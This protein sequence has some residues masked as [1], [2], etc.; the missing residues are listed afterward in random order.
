MSQCSHL[1]LVLLW[2]CLV[3]RESSETLAMVI[4]V[5]GP[6]STIGQ[7]GSRAATLPRAPSLCFQQK[8]G[9]RVHL[10]L[11]SSSLL[12]GGCLLHVRV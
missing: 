5:H 10:A 6:G 3:L 7:K 2:S 9:S 1:L 4:S 12:D 11:H 8:W